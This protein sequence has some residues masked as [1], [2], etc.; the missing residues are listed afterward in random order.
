MADETSAGTVT[1]QRHVN[2]AIA[3]I[4]DTSATNIDDN[5]SLEVVNP[6]VPNEL[7]SAGEATPPSA[8][9]EH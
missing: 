6:A 8:S 2:Q 9:D 5:V 3:A 4:G 1:C 7:I